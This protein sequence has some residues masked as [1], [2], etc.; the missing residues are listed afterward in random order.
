MITVYVLANEQEAI[1]I[2]QTNNLARRLAEH[3]HR[4][5]I[6]TRGRGLWRIVHSEEFSDR[7]SAIRREKAL[8][9]S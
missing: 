1:Y 6:S 2:G 5:T 9:S 7:S 8:K 3:N 4:H